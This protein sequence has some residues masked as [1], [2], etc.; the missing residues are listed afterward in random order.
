L[1]LVAPG[2]ARADETW[3]QQWIGP[4]DDVEQVV[5]DNRLGNV[6]VRGWDRNEVQITAQK[7]AASA[8]ILG[9]LRVHVTK[10]DDGRMAID[11][12]VKF[13]SGELVLPLGSSRVDLVIDAPRG[14]RLGARTWAG[15]L[16]AAGLRGG[17][18]LEIDAGHIDVRDVTGAIVT[19]GRRSDQSITEI[20]GDVDVDDIEGEVVLARIQGERVAARILRGTVR[21]E[22]ILARTIS[23]STMIG[24]VEFVLGEG[25][26]VEV[27]ARAHG[28]HIVVAGRPQSGDFFHR[29]LGGGPD[30]LASAQ[31]H[32]ELVSYGGDVWVSQAARKP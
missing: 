2:L 8:E 19:K 30:E 14:V 27:R 4:A 25:D 21:A 3:Q 9:R 16:S 6:S 32:V 7:R 29:V 10:Y 31:A 12:R 17:A 22:H 18:R 28:G 20:R 13:Q 24:R 5:I 15:D 23:L 11:T 1:L 26:A